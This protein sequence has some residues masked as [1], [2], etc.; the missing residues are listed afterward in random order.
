MNKEKREKLKAKEW[1]PTT[2][3]DFLALAPDEEKIIELRLKLIKATKANNILP[4]SNFLL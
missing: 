2:V 4:K 3:S 1:K